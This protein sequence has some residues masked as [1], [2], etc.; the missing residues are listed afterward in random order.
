MR[1]AL[2]VLIACS[3][4]PA[5]VIIP[6]VQ[7][8][9]SD[10]ITRVYPIRH[11]DPEAMRKV[12]AP[13]ES[14]IQVDSA[15]KA[16]TVK[17]PARTMAEIEATVAR[18]D[19]P[20]AAI[21]NIELTG[22]LLVSVD[23]EAGTIPPEL[24]PVVAKLK[25]IFNY[26]AFQLLDTQSLRLR[27]GVPA[28][29]TGSLGKEDAGKGISKLRVDSASIT[30]DDKGP[31]IRLDGLRLTLQTLPC[32]GAKLTET[33]FTTNIDVREGQKAVVGKAKM[34]GSE[35]TSVLVVTA[36]IVE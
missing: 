14:N 9:T 27:P 17:A 18:F 33:G 2:V 35:R 12:L 4:S 5:Q 20:T 32:A 28:E 24:D 19:V 25:S 30:Q 22:Y 3:L 7:P 26:K 36:R 10:I 11:A 15:L 23:Q 13:F 8:R 34:D 6:N 29:V 21:R 31:V 16:L 1:S